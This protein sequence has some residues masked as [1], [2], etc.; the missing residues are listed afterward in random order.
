[1][2]SEA[3]NVAAAVFLRRGT[4]GWQVLIAR[5]N[6]TH[7]NPA[8]R[9]LWEFPGGKQEAGETIFQC[10]ERE[11]KEE[12]CVPCKAKRVII[13]SPYVYDFGAINLIAIEADLLSEDWTLTVHDAIEWV[14]VQDLPNY[15]FPPADEPVV[16]K[17]RRDYSIVNM[18]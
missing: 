18:T 4:D 14:P 10:L 17:L 2:Q 3:R 5:R 8:M 16:K 7:G 12:L 13:E 6:Q 1:M 15:H 11:I 9:G